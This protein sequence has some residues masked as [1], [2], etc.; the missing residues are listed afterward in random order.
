M[1]A[2]SQRVPQVETFY[3]KDTGTFSY[4]V[5]DGAGDA[6]IIDPVLDYDAASARTSTKSADAILAFVHMYGL[7]VEWILET[8][9]HADHLSAGG[10]LRDKLGAK[11]AIGRG[12]V[13]VQRHFKKLFGFGDAFVADGRQFDRLFDD[14]DAFAIGQYEARVLATPGH[15]GDSLTYVIGDAAFVGDT[16]FAPDIGTARCDF[17]GGDAA[18]L[19]GSIRRIL[20][21]AVETRLFLCHDYPPAAR[22][23]MAETTIAA[24][25][26]DN[27][28]IANGASEEAFVAMRT[29]R[30]ATLA[31]PRLLLPALQVNIR[32][33]RLPEPDA[34]GIA[35]LRLPLDALG[36]KT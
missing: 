33:G 35:Y 13:D 9:A 10:Y 14:D 36:K 31:V 20:A 17:P 23:P 26:Q 11:L 34:N 18:R 7:R 24:Q 19:Y 29:A 21:L 8:H 27:I 30:D 22:E 3:D 4:V 16:V 1:T 32:G 2:T 15:T 6:A 5:R 12:I 25:A 28:H